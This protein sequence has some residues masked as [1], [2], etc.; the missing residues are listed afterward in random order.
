MKEKE[1]D[2]FDGKIRTEQ[3]HLHATLN[4]RNEDK[5]NEDVTEI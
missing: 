1:N 5:K 3:H 2:D 4:Q